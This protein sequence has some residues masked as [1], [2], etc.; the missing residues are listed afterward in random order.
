MPVSNTDG[1]GSLFRVFVARKGVFGLKVVIY[2]S[3]PTNS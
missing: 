3:N 1:I 2:V